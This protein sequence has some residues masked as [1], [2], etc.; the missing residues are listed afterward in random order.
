MLE[1]ITVNTQAAVT[2]PY[3]LTTKFASLQDEGYDLEDISAIEN[4]GLF[5]LQSMPQRSYEKDHETIMNIKI[6]L[7]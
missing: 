5:E 4:E 7:D 1:W 3:R 2:L 6:E